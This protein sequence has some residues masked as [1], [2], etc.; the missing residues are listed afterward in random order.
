MSISHELA[1]E[2][3]KKHLPG[4]EEVGC[5]T[6]DSGEDF[7]E[8]STWC[9]KALIE[10]AFEAGYTDALHGAARCFAENE[11]VPATAADGSIEW[12]TATLRI[13]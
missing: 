1:N 5:T 4:F 11:L 3:A 2:L 7:H 12:V 9:I 6:Q 10:A 13:N 8:A